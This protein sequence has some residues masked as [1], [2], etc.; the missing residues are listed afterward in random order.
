M[1]ELK[2]SSEIQLDPSKIEVVAYDISI[3]DADGIT[4]MI[5]KFSDGSKLDLNTSEDEMNNIAKI[6]IENP[7]ISKEEL[8]N[9]I[10]VDNI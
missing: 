7:N 1:T 4:E 6:L 8:F 5:L 10:M 2:V 3:G 9:K